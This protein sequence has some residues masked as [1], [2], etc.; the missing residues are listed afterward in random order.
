MPEDPMTRVVLGH[1][2]L[3]QAAAEKDEKAQRKLRTE[4]GDAFKEAVKLDGK[5][6]VPHRELGLYYLNEQDLRQ[7]CKELRRYAE[8]APRADDVD[9]VQDYIL[10]LKRGGNCR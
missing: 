6:A 9:R 5:R 4:A 1:L 7:A 2:R 10:E 8:L 3:A